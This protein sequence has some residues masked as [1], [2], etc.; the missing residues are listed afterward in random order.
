METKLKMI[1]VYLSTPED[2]SSFTSN[3]TSIY[4]YN[5]NNSI[6]I[7]TLECVEKENFG[8]DKLDQC[9][10]SE[11]ESAAGRIGATLQERTV[12]LLQRRR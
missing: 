7:N 1:L 11:S 3:L 2:G 5:S 4:T 9:H 10:S 8:F 6:E 12:K